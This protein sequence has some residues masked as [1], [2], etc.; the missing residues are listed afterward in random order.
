[1]FVLE[2]IVRFLFFTLCGWIGHIVVKVVTL[3]RVELDWGRGSESVLAEWVGL[4]FVLLVAGFV[5]SVASR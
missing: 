3:G 4:L 2:L 5:A 1:M